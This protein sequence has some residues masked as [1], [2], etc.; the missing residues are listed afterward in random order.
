MRAARGLTPIEKNVIVTDADGKEIG[1]TYP[2]RAKGLIKNGRAEYADDHTIRLKLT[3]APTADKATEELKMS[4]VIDFNARDFGFDESCVST[5][6]GEVNVG[7]RA[8]VTTQLGN[9]EVWEIG[10]WRWSWSQIKCEKKL[11][12]NTD[13]VFRFSMEGGICSTDDAVTTAQIFPKDGWESRCSYTLDHNKFMPAVCKK[14][15]DGLLRTFELPFNTGETEEWGI[16]L[17]S[18]HAVTRYFAPADTKLLEKLPDISYSD[19]WAERKSE[20][21]SGGASRTADGINMAVESQEMT[22]SEFASQLSRLGDGCNVAFE[23]VTVRA[24]DTPVS[25]SVGD[26]SDGSNIAFESCTLTSR[27]VSVLLAKLGDGC[28]LALSNVTVTDENIGSMTDTGSAGDGTV[29]ALSNVTLPPRVLDLIYANVGD[30]GSIA[31]EKVSTGDVESKT[32]PD[33]EAGSV[34]PAQE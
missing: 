2:R 15:G 5:D 31:A 17:T 27:A 32:D 10:D 7:G 18:L 4:K 22:E 9:T 8:F 1:S 29:I 6:G 33:I 19:W 21:R 28:N 23:R 30:G 34:V 11:E 16:V 26:S 24:D 12:K 20:R 3:R 25:I 13:Y 14:C